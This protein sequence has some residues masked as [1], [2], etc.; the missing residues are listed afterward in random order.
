MQVLAMTIIP[1]I[2]L[3]PERLR[4]MIHP[5]VTP[6]QL[7]DDVKEG[8]FYVNLSMSQ[9]FSN[10]P[11]FN[12]NTATGEEFDEN[13]SLILEE[14]QRMN[15]EARGN[16]IEIPDSTENNKSHP[17]NLCMSNSSLDGNLEDP[18]QHVCALTEEMMRYAREDL[19]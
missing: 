11:E 10:D 13:E 18:D 9:D 8:Y 12:E 7:G 19:N 3:V 1:G 16:D 5:E 17:Y 6:I 15:Q 14:N 4:E 2:L